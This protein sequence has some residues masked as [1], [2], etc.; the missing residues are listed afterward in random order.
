MK[1][2]L[3]R[4][5]AAWIGGTMID[6]NNPWPA[7]SAIAALGGTAGSLLTILINVWWRRRNRAEADWVVTSRSSV[8]TE[9]AH[10]GPVDNEGWYQVTGKLANA[11]DAAAF[12]LTLKTNTGSGYLHTP[13]GSI[14]GRPILHEWIAVLPPGESIEFWCKFPPGKWDEFTLTLDWVT[15]PTRLKRH[16]QF[17]WK[18]S[19]DGPAPK[20]RRP[21]ETTGRYDPIEESNPQ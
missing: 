5:R 12:R 21:N 18:P 16:L 20:P 3:R 19:D 1:I 15:S 4:L 13:S 7:L 8:I 2:G 17:H 6:P 11:G 10:S 14:V 9:D